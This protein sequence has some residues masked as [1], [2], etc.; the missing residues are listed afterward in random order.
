MLILLC[1]IY[2]Q[3]LSFQFNIICVP[4]F[5]CTAFFSK[6]SYIIHGLYLKRPLEIR[7]APNGL[8][9]IQSSFE[10]SKLVSSVDTIL[11][12]T[13]LPKCGYSACT[14]SYNH[15][16]SSNKVDFFWQQ[17]LGHMPYSRMKTI[18]CLSDKLSSKQFFIYFVCLLDR[19]Q[20]LPF[21]DRSIKSTHP[22]QLI[23]VD[24]R[25]PYHIRTYHGFRYF[26]ILVLQCHLDLFSLLQEK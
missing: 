9:V 3:F 22:F 26:L 21:P 17:R 14:T 6:S 20:R 13:Y 18:F 5:N 4:Q 11:A 23:H 2:F 15:V 24:L 7:K 19:Q 1:Q 12:S 10:L 16:T 8:Y 25:G